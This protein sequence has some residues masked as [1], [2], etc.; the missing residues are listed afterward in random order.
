MN[1]VSVTQI[2]ENIWNDLSKPLKGFIKKR[3]KNDQDVEDILQNIFYKIQSN[4]SSL[5]ETDKIH[6]WVFRIARNSIIDYYRGQKFES[7][8][9]ELSEEMISE[10]EDEVTSNE[11]IAQCLKA[12]IQYLPEKYKQAI[13]LTEYQNLTQ[14]EL[15]KRMGLSESGARSRVQRA[16]EKLKE[17]LIGCCTLEF[18]KMGNVIDYEHKYSDCKFC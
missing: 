17:M 10:S 1:D 12:M 15:S 7:I 6:S 5:R 4:I 3:V 2:V 11:E 18:D 14:K 9:I 8:N 13:I 16:R